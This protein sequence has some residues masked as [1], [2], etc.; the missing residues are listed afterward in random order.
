MALCGSSSLGTINIQRISAA[1][2]NKNRTTGPEVHLVMADRTVRLFDF[3]RY[4]W[5]SYTKFGDGC[6]IHWS[7]SSSSTDSS[8]PYCRPK[9]NVTHS[10]PVYK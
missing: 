3:N 2:C 6:G 9:M 1:E 10:N 4:P 7:S 8:S 5:C